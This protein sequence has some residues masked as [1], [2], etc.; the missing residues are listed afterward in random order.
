MVS[1]SFTQWSNSIDCSMVDGRLL[2][3]V[4]LPSAMTVGGVL[5]MVTKSHGEP[6]GDFALGAVTATSRT[7]KRSAKV[8]NASK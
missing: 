7:V 4:S 1:A 6:A 2:R 3:E 5:D 8:P